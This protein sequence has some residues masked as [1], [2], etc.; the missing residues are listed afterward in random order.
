M[1][2]FKTNHIAA[3]C[4]T[5]KQMVIV[6]DSHSLDHQPLSALLVKTIIAA[7]TILTAF[8][9]RDSVMQGIQ[10]I[11]PNNATKKFLF[12]VMITLFFL[13]ATVLMAYM[14]QDKID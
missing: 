10:A 11:A 2:I 9:I 6:S 8:S 14:W 1:C 3:F 5:I 7:F 4:L 13:F 12:T